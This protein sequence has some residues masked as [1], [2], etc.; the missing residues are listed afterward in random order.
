MPW[1]LLRLPQPAGRLPR[2]LRLLGE[3]ARS[4]R[5]QLTDPAIGVPSPESS[6]PQT[7]PPAVWS[8]PHGLRTASDWSWR[9]IVV[10]GALAGLVYLL[11]LFSEVV[12]PVLVALLLA[13]LLHPVHT[14]LARVMPRG[15]AAFITV[16]GTLAVISG[17]LSFVG[18]QLVDQLDDITNRVG[19][20][21]DTIRQWA[22]GTLGITDSQVQEWIDRARAAIS[23][24]NLGDLATSAG[25]TLGRAVA[26]FFLA[27]FTLFFF[28]Y[29]GRTIW[30]W[31]TRLFPRG[32]RG[33]V[34]SSGLVAWSQLSAYTRTT[35]LIA[36]IDAIFIGS[37][38]AILGVPFAS[39]VGLIVFFGAFIP[40]IGALTSGSVAVLLALVGLGPVK[41]LVML[42]IVL[43]VQQIESHLLQ[44][45]LM[46]RAMRIHPLAVII[47]LGPAVVLAGFAGALVAVPIV[48]VID[49]VTRHLVSTGASAA[50]QKAIATTTASAAAV[51]GT[52]DAGH[53]NP[54]RGRPTG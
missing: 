23:S 47:A 38:A 48:A 8:V 14:A 52:D 31:V 6:A 21:I 35:V 54:V 45:I 43:T 36:A 22:R 34:A 29:D 44:P 4:R 33:Q 50:A 17:L 10:A 46:G 19:E 49:A 27:M 15:L 12:V 51:T 42:A 24:A 16:I 53:P 40:I 25:F 32:A 39:G 11:G 26:G 2:A 7:P 13:A 41:A 28:L 9:A 20:G 1:R 5:A 37:G 18:T 3:R 30:G